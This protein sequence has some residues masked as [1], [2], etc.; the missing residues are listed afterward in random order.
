MAR[1]EPLRPKAWPPQMRE[2]LA[3]LTPPEPRHPN[4][5]SKDRP[6]AMNTLGTLAHHPAL[7][8][9]FFPFNGHVLL[10]TTLST[11]QREILILR[12]A[13]LRDCTYEW[14]QHVILGGDVGL[15]D[16]DVA[17]I[18]E[19]PD[20]PGWDPLEQAL[21]RS[22]DELI[23]GGAITGETWAVLAESFDAQQFLDVIFTVGAYETLAWMMRSFDLELD[24]DLRRA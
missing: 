24:D 8:R 22:V 23:G 5:I 4:P 10:A 9:A 2:A 6:K 1:I 13:A 12:A 15:D 11:R 17:R 3:G 14:K 19:G 18:A 7:A 20:A 21:V 16:K